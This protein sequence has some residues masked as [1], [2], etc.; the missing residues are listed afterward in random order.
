MKLQYHPLQ[1]P[2]LLTNRSDADYRYREFEPGEPLRPYVACYWTVETRT[3]SPPGK[4]RVIPDGCVDII[5]D[6]NASSANAF[7]VGIMTGCETPSLAEDRSLLGI[8]FFAEG[9]R[10]FIR[11]PVSELGGRHVPLEALW[12][13]EAASFLDEAREPGATACMRVKAGCPSGSWR[14]SSA[15]ASATSEGSS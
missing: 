12:G 2:V 15:T 9:A 13:S 10:R 4:H 3:S 1:P 7:A 14:R 5:I 6:L 8:R 11:C